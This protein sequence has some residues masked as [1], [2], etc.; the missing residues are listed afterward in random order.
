MRAKGAVDLGGG[1][2]TLKRRASIVGIFDDNGLDPGL[3]RDSTVTAQH[4]LQDKVPLRGS[5]ASKNE[6]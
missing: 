6:T 4:I 3:K 2:L 5:R 1:L